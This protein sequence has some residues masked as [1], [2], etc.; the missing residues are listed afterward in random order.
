MQK[1]ESYDDYNDLDEL[2]DLEDYK[3]VYRVKFVGYNDLDQE[4]GFEQIVVDDFENDKQAIRLADSLSKDKIKNLSS[5]EYYIR[6]NVE[7]IIKGSDFIEYE[8]L[9]YSRVI[10]IK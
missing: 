9:I 10:I 8:E 5:D 2:D 4:T 6:V 1:Q 3:L 7:P